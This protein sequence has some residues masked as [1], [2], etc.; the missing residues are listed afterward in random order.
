[1]Q[2]IS[3]FL[4]NLTEV[5]IGEFNK[6]TKTTNYTT[7]AK[8]RGWGYMYASRWIKKY[9]WNWKKTY[10]IKGELNEPAVHI[11]F[12]ETQMFCKWKNKRLTSEYQWM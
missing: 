12:D 2:K 10:G 6:F 9:G 4:I 8:K 5:S 7:E 11:N 3:Y 1:M